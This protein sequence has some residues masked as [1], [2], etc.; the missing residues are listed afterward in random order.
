M[1]KVVIVGGGTS[2]WSAAAMLSK[3]QEINISILR[4]WYLTK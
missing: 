3:N 2:G 4:I 1:N